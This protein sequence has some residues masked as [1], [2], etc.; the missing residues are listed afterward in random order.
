MEKSES[1]SELAGALNKFQSEMG[2]VSFDSNNPFFKSKYA[3]LSA[4]VTAAR[5]LLAKNGLSVSQLVSDTGSVTTMLLHSSGQ[6]LSSTLTLKAVKEDPQGQGSAITYARRY[7][8]AAILGIV[9]DE[10]DDGNA[11]TSGVKELITEKQL[12]TLLDLINSKEL[13][14]GPLLKY[15]EVDRLEDIKASDYMKALQAI[16][17]AKKPEAKK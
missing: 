9:S 8:Y 16:N 4:L 11:A 13:T 17:V 6:Y 2:T 12:S 15:M 1:L 10:D 7:A 3:S 5:P 14:E